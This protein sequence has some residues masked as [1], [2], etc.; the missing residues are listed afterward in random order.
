MRVWMLILFL[1]LASC[2][3]GGG[4]GSSSKERPSV[5]SSPSPSPSLSPSA[6]PSPSPSPSPEPSAVAYVHPQGS[7]GNPGTANQPFLTLQAAIN[8]LYN[9]YQSGIVRVAQ[10]TYDLST[11]LILKPSVSLYGGYKEDNWE[12]RNSSLY[13][14]VIQDARTSGG[15][16]STPITAVYLNSGLGD[17]IVDGFTIRG[18]NAEYSTAVLTAGAYAYTFQHNTIIGGN[19]SG[20]SYGVKAVGDVLMNALYQENTIVGGSGTF[21]YGIFI[22]GSGTYQDNTV[23]AG[24][25]TS[26]FGMYLDTA[27]NLTVTGNTVTGGSGTNSHGIYSHTTNATISE[28]TVDGG[29][30]STNSYG[31]YLSTAF[32]AEPTVTDNQITGG[33]SATTRGMYVVSVDAAILRNVIEGGTATVTSY[34][35]YANGTPSNFEENEIS[36]GVSNLNSYGVY[37][38]NSNSPTFIDN[39]IDGGRAANSAYALYFGFSL[40]S[41]IQNN[42][43]STSA[44]VTRYCV[45]DFLASGPMQLT[46]NIFQS[47]STALLY[48][49]AGSCNQNHD[50]DGN[51]NTCGINDINGLGGNSGNQSH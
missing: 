39:T 38:I 29:T 4:S 8:Y 48:T 19:N 11:G 44:G 33:R 35:I 28:N 1:V 25:G 18:A 21:S 41:V 22:A 32:S 24:S 13:S 2:K 15:N 12:T 3:S 36:G 7:D 10:G 40:G 43:L 45:Y 50:G 47:C 17:L 31:M 20:Y 30:G 27:L 51:Q 16:S 37:V 49:T 46:S 42:T 6:S 5:P 34:G 9:N 14:T 26:N 23:S